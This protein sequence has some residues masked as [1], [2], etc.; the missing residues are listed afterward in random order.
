MSTQPLAPDLTAAVMQ[1][2]DIGPTPPDL[3]L[4]DALFAAYGQ[5]VPWESIFR[6][7]RRSNIAEL[8]ER[9][10]FAETF[11]VDAIERGGGGTCFESNYAL[12]SLLLALGYEG[13]L[14]INDM[15]ETAACHSAVI[16]HID[17]EKWLADAGLPLYAPLRLDPAQTTESAHHIYTYS[18]T[19]LDN[20]VYRIERRP[21]G[22]PYC[23]TLIDSVVEDADYRA[24]TTNDYDS[25][26]FFLDRAIVLKVVGGE[27]WR[28]DSNNLNAGFQ[29]FVDG[30]RS[31]HPLMGDLAI[32]VGEFFGM[33]TGMVRAAL[34]ILGIQRDSL[35]G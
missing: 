31:D 20:G 33:N 5:T 25:S 28:F 2:L 10:R 19:P 4:L 7:V 9:P 1:Y 17:G 24:A 22:D 8:S 23:Y 6:I 26:G 27:L 3:H 15:G 11:W 21:H 29:R 32:N 34:R 18:A 12:L 35:I 30:E 13:Y 14:T 16:L